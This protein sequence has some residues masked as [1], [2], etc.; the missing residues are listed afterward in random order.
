MDQNYAFRVEGSDEKPVELKIDPAQRPNKGDVVSLKDGKRA[1]VKDV[2]LN[3]E[4]GKHDVTLE[5]VPEVEANPVIAAEG[6]DPHPERHAVKD[7]LFDPKYS[8][9]VIDAVA[10]STKHL[11]RVADGE[12]RAK[13]RDEHRELVGAGSTPAGPH[14]KAAAQT[15]GVA[16]SFNPA[17][18]APIRK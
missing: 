11:D 3:L 16:S 8:P 6:N 7:V 13:Q 15:G 18:T 1:R 12:K 5:L 10:E 4:T 14:E 2:V 17:A 9:K